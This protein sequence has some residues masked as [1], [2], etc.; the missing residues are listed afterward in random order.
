M[1][2]FEPF[3]IELAGRRYTA[4]WHID[5]PN[6]CVISEHGSGR[7]ALGRGKPRNVAVKV[8]RGIVGA[9]GQYPPG[10]GIRRRATPVAPTPGRLDSASATQRPA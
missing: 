6:V 1:A 10:A 7:L 2:Q 8:L 5:G 3:H 4:T 9:I